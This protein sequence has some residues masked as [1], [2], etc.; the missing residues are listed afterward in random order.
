MR[1]KRRRPA[2]TMFLVHLQVGWLLMV[3]LIVLGLPGQADAYVD[4]NTG[5]YIFQILFPIVSAIVAA[6]LFFKSQIVNMWK[7]VV[8][9]VR[10]PKDS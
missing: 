6:F 8:G 7:K 4:P 9:R 1:V 10:R 2:P 5:G 3:L